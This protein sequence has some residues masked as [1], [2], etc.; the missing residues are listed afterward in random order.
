MHLNYTHQ[1]AENFHSKAGTADFLS[2]S[3]HAA[4]IGP[5]LKLVNQPGARCPRAPDVP[6]PMIRTILSYSTF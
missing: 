6:T 3:F 5:M 1:Q 2:H 4:P